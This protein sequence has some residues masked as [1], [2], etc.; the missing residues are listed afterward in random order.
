MPKQPAKQSE[1]KPCHPVYIFAGNHKEYRTWLQDN[2]HPSLRHLFREVGQI[3]VVNGGCPPPF[4]VHRIGTWYRRPVQ[5]I[6]YLAAVED[7]YVPSK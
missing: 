4:Y 5:E 7:Y 1:Q 6:D 3:E 2:I